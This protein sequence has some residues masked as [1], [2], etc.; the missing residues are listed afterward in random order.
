MP[1]GYRGIVYQ[2]IA[3]LAK[4]SMDDLHCIAIPTPFPVG[5]VN[6][7]LLVGEE[8]A[9]VDTGPNTDEALAVLRTSLAAY[10][11]TLADIRYLVIT[12]AHPDH[13]GLAARIVAESGARVCSHHIN[14]PRLANDQSEVRQRYAYYAQILHQS[15]VPLSSLAGLQAELS[16]ALRYAQ[17]VTVDVALNDRDVLTLAGAS[18]EVI[19]TPGHARGH[20]C[21]YNPENRYLLSGDHL[22]SDISSNPILEPP[23]PGEIERPRSLAQY[24][25]SLKRLEALEIAVAWPGHGVPITDHR[26]LIDQ[27]MQFHRQRAEEIAAILSEEPKTASQ[28]ATSLFSDLQGIQILLAVSEV[29]GHLDILEEEG[30]VM[31]QQTGGVVRYALAGK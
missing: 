15:G 20:I 29:I 26:S 7:Y 23:L 5:P 13:Y 19:H 31:A 21:L 1:I 11:Y 22:L 24:L 2:T 17:P 4:V 10:G 8:L 14:V 27:R 30:R 12:H 18:W 16:T 9:L 3:R 28:I 25:R 6:V